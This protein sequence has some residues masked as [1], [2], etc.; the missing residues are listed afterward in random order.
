MIKLSLPIIVILITVSACHTC[1]PESVH[2]VY[3]RTAEPIIPVLTWAD[4]PGYYAL[5]ETTTEFDDLQDFFDD[6][7]GYLKKIENLLQ[8][9]EEK[10]AEE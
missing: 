9:Y 8:L 2:I 7:E 10:P 3:P 4:I 1:P 6:Y 5:D